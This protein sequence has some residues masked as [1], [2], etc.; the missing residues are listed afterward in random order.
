MLAY[1][2]VRQSK[3]HLNTFWR[4]HTISFHNRSEKCNVLCWFGSVSQELPK[5]DP[6]LCEKLLCATVRSLHLNVILSNIQVQHYSTAVLRQLYSGF[7]NLSCV[8]CHVVK[9]TIA[10]RNHEMNL[11][12]RLCPKVPVRDNKTPA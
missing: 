2:Y 4:V 7:G 3:I 6:M 8:V 1:E 5:S 10:R 11:T 9:I 12:Q